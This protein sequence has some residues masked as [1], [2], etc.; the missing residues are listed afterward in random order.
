ML[1]GGGKPVIV[2]CTLEDGFR[3]TPEALE[4]AITPK[5]KWLIFNQPSNP[6]GACY[7]REQLKAPDRCADEAS[8]CL[9]ADRRHV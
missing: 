7:T 5:T 8:A 4:K 3:L 1:L 9:G 2:E 6:T